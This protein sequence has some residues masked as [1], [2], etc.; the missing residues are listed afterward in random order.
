MFSAC[1]PDVAASL[2]A[3]PPGKE[4][5]STSLTAIRA[6]DRSTRS[7]RPRNQAAAKPSSG[8]PATSQASSTRKRMAPCTA[9]GLRWGKG[10]K[11]EGR[12][13]SKYGGG[14]G[15]GRSSTAGAVGRFVSIVSNARMQGSSHEAGCADNGAAQRR[16]P[17]SESYRA[18]H[19]R[20]GSADL[21]EA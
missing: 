18:A 1:I 4:I 12:R 6:E 7:T 13:V 21:P 19:L 5:S 20:S 11:G 17:K 2:P 15:G 16:P 14:G 3:A 10:K 9:A 8:L